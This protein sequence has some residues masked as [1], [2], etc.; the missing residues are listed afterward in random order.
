MT[1]VSLKPIF[2]VAAHGS[3]RAESNTEVIDLASRL[4]RHLNEYTVLPAFLELAEPRLPEVI[5]AA[6]H[7]GATEMVVFPFFLGS[8]VHVN[9]DLPHLLERKKLQYPQ[10]MFR[11]LPH[12]GGDPDWIHW[13]VEKIKAL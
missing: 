2:I 10:V 9:T 4:Q 12:L 11:Q 8:G 6:A 5:D 13:L 1:P 7:Q 3:R